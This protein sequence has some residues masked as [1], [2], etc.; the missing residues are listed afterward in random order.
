M[1]PRPI[2]PIKVAVTIS[3][4]LNFNGLN[5]GVVMCEQALNV[6]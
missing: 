5:I 1:G 4:M 6:Q 3:T 2:L